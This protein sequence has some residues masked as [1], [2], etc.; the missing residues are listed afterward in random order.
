MKVKIKRGYSFLKNPIKWFKDRDKIKVLEFL[1]NNELDN[2]L[3][4]EIYKVENDMAVYGIGGLDKNRKRVH[5]R[6]LQKMKFKHGE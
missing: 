5:P 6:K 2:G 4:D 1:V 3:A